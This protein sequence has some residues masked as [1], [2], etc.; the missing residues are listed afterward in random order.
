MYD[1]I[2]QDKILNKFKNNIKNNKLVHAYILNGEKG[3]G[4]KL[5]SK[6]VSAMILCKDEDID[7]RPCC[8]CSS[9]KKIVSKNHP[10]LH[11]FTP[12]KKEYTVE[13]LEDIQK[14]MRRK[15]NESKNSVFI[16]EEGEKLSISFQNKF[17]K[18]LE[19]PPE[20]VIIMILVDNLD[21]LLDT[22]VSRARVINVNRISD[23]EFK[24][25]MRTQL[26]NEEDID[27]IA[28]FA[29]GNIGKAMDLVNDMAFKKL[30]EDVIDMA[31]A[32][33]SKKKTKIIEYLDF[34]EENEEF[35]EDIFDIMLLWYRDILIYSKT[36][37]E[38]ALVNRDK[39][40]IIKVEES[41]ISDKNI[42]LIIEKLE[43]TKNRLAHNANFTNTISDFLVSS[44]FL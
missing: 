4:K 13:Q 18:L 29:N 21:R 1:I 3:Q 10:D 25:Y 7:S 44:S 42:Y 5:I 26:S 12:S 9:C 37:S 6:E 22:T 2:G 19:E 40:D 24:E 35:I 43:E 11:I 14:I 23:D 20:S 16:F 31:N 17:L 32:I 34:F 30:R 28:S 27:F 38:Y 33:I 41:N 15:P 36:N 39:Y 8:K